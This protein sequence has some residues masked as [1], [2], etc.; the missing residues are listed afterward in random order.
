MFP[1]DTLK[2]WEE[3]PNDVVFSDGVNNKDSKW[4]FGWGGHPFDSDECHISYIKDD[5]TCDVY[6][7]P[8]Y[9]NYMLLFTKKTAKEKVQRN[10]RYVLGLN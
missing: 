5:G 4:T 8:S 7:C 3:L 9:I 1:N 2:K 6:P 10:I